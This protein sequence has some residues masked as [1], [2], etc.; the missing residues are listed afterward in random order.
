MNFVDEWEAIA[1]RIHGL[2]RAAE[3]HAR[4]LAIRESDS[5]GRS[6][7]LRHQSADVLSSIEGFRARF[8]AALPS[9]A[10]SAI[11]GFLSGTAALIREAEGSP[12]SRE[13]RVWAGLV[14]L[15]AFEA[16]ISYLLSSP[17]ERIRARSE[18]AFSH[19]QRMI[20]VDEDIRTKWDK[21]FDRGE[22]VCEQLGA[23]HLLWHGICAFK[24]DAAGARTD[25]VFP[26]S[27]GGPGDE[28]RFAD[29]L[30]L[31]EWKLAASDEVVQ[32]RFE[33]A[34]AQAQRYAEGPLFA[35]ELLNYRYAV[36]VSRTQVTVPDDLMLGSTLYRHINIAVNPL[37]PS[38][39]SKI[40]RDRQPSPY[41]RE[42]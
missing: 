11:D 29:G 32:T 35:N 28:A 38:R 34:R 21:A 18:V 4:F 5:Y 8:D 26:E 20:A 23:V 42:T 33:E 39:A 15:S 37:V 27:S 7:R 22:V 41:A 1:S 9:S 14:M 12:D 16:E 10:A 19:L 36:V 31:T 25:L 40:R 6:R 13:E 30:V 24:V 2:V 17:Q 3:L